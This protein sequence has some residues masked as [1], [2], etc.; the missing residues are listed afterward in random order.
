MKFISGLSGLHHQTRVVS[1]SLVIVASLIAVNSFP[2]ASRANEC[3]DATVVFARGSSQNKTALHLDAPLSKEF[4]EKENES[5]SFFQRFQEEL[6]ANYPKVNTKYV[7][8]HNFE[9]QYNPLGYEAKGIFGW[10]DRNNMLQAE[11]S[12]WPNGQYNR[13]VLNGKQEL[14]GYVKD[15][16]ALCPNQLIVLGG[17]SQGAQVVGESLF[18]FTPEERARI[19]AVAL[20]GDPKFVAGTAGQG[21][22]FWKESKPFPWKRGSASERERGMADPRQPYVPDDM[23]YK[24]FSWCFSDD[25]IC[26]G[27]SGFKLALNSKR[28]IKNNTTGHSRYKA[29]GIPEAVKEITQTIS[30]RLYAANKANGGI[31]EA[32]GPDQTQPSRPN[33]VPQDVVFLVNTSGE[34]KNTISSIRYFTGDV[35]GTVNKFYAGA[36]YGVVDFSEVLQGADYIPRTNVRQ[37][38]APYQNNNLTHTMAQKLSW[39]GLGG[40]GADLPDPHAL[41]IEKAIQNQQWDEKATKH[42]VL[43]TDRPAKETQTYNVCNSSVQSNMITEVVRPCNEAQNYQTVSTN[44]GSFYCA[45]IQIVMERQ[46]CKLRAS[47]PYYINKITRSLNDAILLANSKGVAI[48][49]VAHQAMNRADVDNNAVRQQ[50]K[51]I[52]DRTGGLFLEYQAF[53]KPQYSDV[54]WKVLTHKPKKLRLTSYDNTRFFDGVQKLSSVPKSYVAARSNVPTVLDVASNSSESYD[55]YKWD[56][57]SDGIWDKET[58]SPTV[59]YVFDSSNNSDVLTVAAIDNDVIVASVALPVSVQAYD[60]PAVEIPEQP[61]FDSSFTTNRTEEDLRVSWDVTDEYAP[62]VVFIGDQFGLPI[63]SAPYTQGH[64]SLKL[65]SVGQGGELKIWLVKDGVSSEKHTLTVN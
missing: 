48:T 63:K 22:D 14:V 62:G 57:N 34:V 60:G 55:S 65:N 53:D 10:A 54:M 61:T 16:I 13:S 9:D 40:G 25:F 37:G 11:L 33:F 18:E 43:F 38:L 51:S 42:L 59:E 47:Q 50:I 15:Q 17:Y 28:V 23:T 8:V 58:S 21:V 64:A 44:Q 41:A 27:L 5:G 39:G 29:V 7:S 56:F 1:V 24:T 46:N 4:F 30:P 6:E 3:S 20:F 19:N 26:S 2:L 45:T 49:V 31:D 12:W 52:A 32:A 36:R 35:I